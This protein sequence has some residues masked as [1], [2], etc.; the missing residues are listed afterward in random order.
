M[1]HQVSGAR[2]A[3]R[4]LARMTASERFAPLPRIATGVGALD[5]S[6]VRPVVQERLD[7]AGQTARESGLE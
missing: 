7:H 2:D 3:L 1:I 6:D 5:W 4:A